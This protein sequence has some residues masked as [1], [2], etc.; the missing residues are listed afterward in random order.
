MSKIET[1]KCSNVAIVALLLAAITACST[2]ETLTESLSTSKATV[3]CAGVSMDKGTAPTTRTGSSWEYETTYTKY[4]ALAFHWPDEAYKQSDD[5]PASF[6]GYFNTGIASQEW[7]GRVNRNSSTYLSQT[8]N[9]V[10]NLNGS[11]NESSYNHILMGY[12]KY[13]TDNGGSEIP[14]ITYDISNVAVSNKAIFYEQKAAN[15]EHLDDYNALWST[16]SFSES[17]LTSINSSNGNINDYTPNIHFTFHHIPAVLRFFVTNTGKSKRTITNVEIRESEGTNVFP[18]RV[19][20]TCKNDLNSGKYDVKDPEFTYET[21]SCNAVA[22]NLSADENSWNTLSTNQTLAAYAL[23]LG[24]QEITDRKFI[25]T[26]TD[27]KG[28]TYTSLTLSGSKIQTALEGFEDKKMFLP[29]YVYTFELLLDDELAL[30]G[31]NVTNWGDITDGDQQGSEDA[32]TLT[33]L[34]G[35]DY[36]NL[37]QSMTTLNLNGESITAAEVT[38]YMQ[39]NFTTYFQNVT[40]IKFTGSTLAQT[41]SFQGI[42]TVTAIDGVSF[43]TLPTSAF[44]G[45]NAIP[46]A[47]IGSFNLPNVETVGSYCFKRCGTVETLSLPKMTMGSEQAFAFNSTLKYVCLASMK[48]FA[49]CKDLFTNSDNITDLAFGTSDAMIIPDGTTMATI[50]GGTPTNITLYLNGAEYEA[51]DK[52]ANTWRGVTFKAIERYIDYPYKKD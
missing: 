18:A 30:G 48:D 49:G 9:I 7:G 34:C 46:A 23:A 42:T 36:V 43:V 40:T 12:G 19:E 50:L 2:D 47:S 33:A 39:G 6:Y 37:R 21:A 15:T 28:N 44:E 26:V 20:F 4:K 10:L 51:A 52:T 29:G 41:H 25:F 32:S 11:G 3:L 35:T 16:T 27:D 13:I 1:T 5:A 17:D 24:N 14:I 22:V 8:G 38:A 31:V 45:E